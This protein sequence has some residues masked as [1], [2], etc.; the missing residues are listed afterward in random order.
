MLAWPFLAACLAFPESPY[1]LVRGTPTIWIVAA[2]AAG[3]KWG[4]PGALVL[5][6]PSLLPF[7]V[8]GVRHRGWWVALLLLA[9]LTVP[10]LSL[11]PDWIAAVTNGQGRGGVLYSLKDVP[12]VMIPVIAW[13]G[14]AQ[15]TEIRRACETCAC[16][17]RR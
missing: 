1:E 3:L 11:V 4:W 9:V 17:L 14:A 8:I 5:L 10:L 15:G 13:L 7:A 12:L 6:K 16:G 2:V